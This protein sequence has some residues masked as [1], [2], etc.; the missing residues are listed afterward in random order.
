M[1]KNRILCREYLKAIWK[2]FIFF[3]AG[4]WLMEG[5]RERRGEQI[6]Q[7]ETSTSSYF[8]SMQVTAFRP[9]LWPALTQFTFNQADHRP[10]LSP[11]QSQK[12]SVE[13]T[14]QGRRGQERNKYS[15]RID[16]T[17]LP[18]ISVPRIAWPGVNLDSKQLE[19]FF[20]SHSGTVLLWYCGTV[21]LWYCGTVAL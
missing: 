17:A 13:R 9:Q 7:K 4:G 15:A 21:V 11:S 8:L 14:G 1:N 10:S 5:E 20:L 2:E 18:C 6:W 3:E 16:W 12:L 19:H